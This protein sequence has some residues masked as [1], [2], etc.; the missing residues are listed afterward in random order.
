MLREGRAL[1]D[2]IWEQRL[3]R[4]LIAVS[5]QGVP[6]SAFGFSTQERLHAAFLDRFGD[7]CEH[8]SSGRWHGA[9]SWAGA[10]LG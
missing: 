6:V 3:M 10:P 2:I 8:F 4:A 7:F 5:L 1:T 9:L